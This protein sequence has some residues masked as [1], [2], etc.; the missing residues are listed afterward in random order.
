MPPS[1]PSTA[2]ILSIGLAA[3]ASAAVL[4]P[5]L[6]AQPAGVEE[7]DP[8]E[9]RPVS[10]VAFEGLGSVSRQFVLNNVRTVAGRPLDLEQV[11]QDLRRLERT[12]RFRQVRADTIELEDGTIV[13]RFTLTEAPVVRDIV[14]VGN[15]ELSDQELRLAV[16]ADVRLIVGV[17]IDD[18][19]V[20]AAARRIETLYR[21]KGYYQVEV[22]IDESE[23]EE[24]ATII[25]RVRE[26]ARLQVTDVRFD[27]NDSFEARTLRQEV[28]TEPRGILSSSPLDDAKLDRDVQ[29][30]IEFYR[31]SGFLD[32]RASRTVLPSPNGRE[33]IVTFIIDEGARYTLRRVDVQPA[34]QTIPLAVLSA[35]QVR[36]LMTID[37][38]DTF[39]N[40]AIDASQSAIQN[41]LRQMG[42]ANARV[43]AEVFRDTEAALVDVRV[44]II[45]GRRFRT[46][47]VVIAGN[48]LTQDKVIRRESE[49]LPGSWLDGTARDQTTRR[50]RNRNLFEPRGPR[51]SGPRVSIQ[52]ED[53]ADPG[54]RDV[55]I[56]V[57]E[58]NTGTFAFGASVNSD[59]GLVGAITLNQRNFDIGDV[60][61]TLDEL[62]RGRAFRGGG[63]TFNL[64]LQPGSQVSTY[65]I[66]LSEPSVFDEPYALSGTA[67]L[68]QREFDQYDEQRIGGRS[69]L[70]RRFGTRWNGSVQF[71]GEAIEIDSIDADA[72]VD[73]FDVEGDSNLSSI[74][75]GLNRTTVDN[76][77]RP[78]EGT[79]TEFGVEQVGALGGDYTFS[80]L[81][82]EHSVFLTID[83]DYL[84][85]PT[86]VQL[87]TQ[88]SYIPQEDEAPIFER[89]Y[90]GGR[91]FRGFD[92]RGVGPVGVRNDTGEL[93]G[94]HVGG[95]FLFFFGVEVEKPLYGDILGGVI[96]IDSGTIED[97]FGLD[98]YRVSIG[99][100]LRIYLAAF[101]QAPLALDFGFPIVD[102]ET[103]EREV[104]S[105]SVD[106]PF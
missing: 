95:D 2:R 3:L 78:T 93:G 89:L 104:F 39:S 45:E 14:V 22:T 96:F 25:F 24:T 36:G 67:F 13:V 20:D 79:R 105:F 8:L 46:G 53:A 5:T 66:G 101:G 41:A 77:F 10:E 102:E 11:R 76:R 56:E 7:T 90:L 9:G 55:L 32:V 26:G 106:L 91:S 21:D 103:D 19:R 29:S 58:T 54:Y 82:A 15:R 98:S 44:E 60:P 92:F 23:L 49:L 50:L 87:K 52:P 68:R 30:I 37:T 62:L 27:G 34:D 99:T 17:P 71:R 51:S 33:A 100:G 70:G 59:S 18:F 6:I 72:P 47:L 31:N 12:G 28:E 64:A 88:I 74:T 61:D 75:I 83:R 85:R 16:E 63:Q 42:Y 84:D 69:G 80:K 81:R 1:R 94:D 40:E 86:V 35:E 38:G 4:T 97:D 48:E 73:L 43:S 57:E 65:S